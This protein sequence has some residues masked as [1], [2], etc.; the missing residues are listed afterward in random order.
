MNSGQPPQK[1]SPQ[2]IQVNPSAENSGQ[3]LEWIQANPLP[4]KR[5]RWTLQLKI[6]ANSSAENWEELLEWIQVNLPHPR[7]IQ[8]NPSVEF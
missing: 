6:K 5:F 3:L 7:K 1:D 8:V 2:K 4:P